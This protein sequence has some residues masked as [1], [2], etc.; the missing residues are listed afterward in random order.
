MVNRNW[1]NAKRIKRILEDNQDYLD[2]EYG[3]CI[4]FH[5][6]VPSS[7][8]ICGVYKMP[9]DEMIG[10][11][12]FSPYYVNH[13]TAYANKI[14]LCD[15]RNIS[16]LYPVESLYEYTLTEDGRKVIERE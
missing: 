13:S 14:A 7:F 10:V 2:N 11:L 12:K 15:I 16:N 6:D 9:S 8:V 1:I 5:I 3:L 4:E